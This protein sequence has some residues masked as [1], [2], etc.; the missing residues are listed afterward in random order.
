[1]VK[2]WFFIAVL[3]INFTNGIYLGEEKNV[4]T[5]CISF[6]LLVTVRMRVIEFIIPI[7]QIR[8][9]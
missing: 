5:D 6:Q 8:Q 2:P 9:R 7:R 1:M 4:K 3:A